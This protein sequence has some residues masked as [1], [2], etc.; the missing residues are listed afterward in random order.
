IEVFEKY[1]NIARWFEQVS[2][3]DA[4]QS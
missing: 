4:F 1:P 3:R 2:A